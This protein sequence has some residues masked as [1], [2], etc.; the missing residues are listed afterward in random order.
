MLKRDRQ[1]IITSIEARIRNM[2]S[3]Y[4]SSYTDPN[5]SVSLRTPMSYGSLDGYS[6]YYPTASNGWPPQL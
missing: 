6:G 4:Q 1:Q 5:I 3:S 2:H